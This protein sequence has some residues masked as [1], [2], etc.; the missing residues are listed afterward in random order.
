MVGDSIRVGSLGERIAISMRNSIV[1]GELRDGERLTEESLAKQFEV[2]RG[3]VRDALRVLVS[4]QLLE[5]EKRGYIVRAISANDIDELYAARQ[6]IETLALRTAI[7]RG[8]DANWGASMKA[9]EKMQAAADQTNYDSYA[10]HDLEFH[11]NFYRV[12]ENRRLLNMWEQIAPTFAAIMSETN[13][14]DMDLHPSLDD[15][16]ELLRAVTAGHVESALEQLDTHLEGSRR[17]IRKLVPLN[18]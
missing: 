12:A 10:F 7:A 11:A 17:R 3:P 8:S 18:D 4:E 14:Q 13:R 2:S 1:R 16:K 6:A 15:H 5:A 9:L